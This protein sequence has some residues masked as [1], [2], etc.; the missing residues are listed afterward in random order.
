VL[1]NPFV[2]VAIVGMRRAAEADENAAL[3]DDLDGR[4]DLAELHERFV[5]AG[6]GGHC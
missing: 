2:D 6:E 5:E 4:F 3:C 1:S